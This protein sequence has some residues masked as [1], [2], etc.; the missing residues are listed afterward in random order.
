[1]AS[2]FCI[3]FGYAFVTVIGQC[4][5]AGDTRAAAY[6][7]KKLLRMTYIGSAAFSLSNGLRNAGDIRFTMYAS[8]FATVVCRVIFSIVLGVWMDLGVIG[9]CLAM[10]GDWLVKAALILVRYRSRKW[11][12]FQV[13]N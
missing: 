7:N 1:M 5:G 2:L 3:A 13:I 11:T 10:V 6:Y 8:I 4:M 9:I 12:K